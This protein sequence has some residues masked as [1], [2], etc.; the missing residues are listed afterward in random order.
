MVG[1]GDLARGCDSGEISKSV[2][3]LQLKRQNSV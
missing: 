3:I 2:S 1:S